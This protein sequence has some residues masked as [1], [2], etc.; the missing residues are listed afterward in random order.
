MLRAQKNLWS[1][2]LNKQ[3]ERVCHR[4]SYFKAQARFL[5]LYSSANYKQHYKLAELKQAHP[6][7]KQLVT[8]VVD[9]WTLS[10]CWVKELEFADLGSGSE[11]GEREVEK[12]FWLR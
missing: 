7:E 12:K 11:F 8:H 10:F 3:R 9:T 2:L 6:D 5:S 4:D 1:L